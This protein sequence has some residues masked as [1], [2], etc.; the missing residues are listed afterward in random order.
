MTIT[1]FKMWIVCF[2][3]IIQIPS[4]RYVLDFFSC[5]VCRSMLEIY[6][7][8]YFMVRILECM[9]GRCSLHHF[10]TLICKIP[11]LLSLHLAYR[12]S[13]YWRDWNSWKDKIY[14]SLDDMN[15]I[16]AGFQIS[17]FCPKILSYSYIASKI[18][19]FN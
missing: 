8:L 16:K 19:Q 7:L 9:L 3:H 5:A 12:F 11:W 6:A 15:E 4:F 10:N 18:E 14:I 2:R 1:L 17:L 13:K